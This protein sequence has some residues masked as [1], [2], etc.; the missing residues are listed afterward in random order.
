MSKVI[1]ETIAP[2]YTFEMKTTNSPLV[3]NIS[4]FNHS[5][6][7]NSTTS[8][9]ILSTQIIKYINYILYEFT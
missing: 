5:Y 1:I 8:L 6:K 3:K 4:L 2:Y 9:S 7:Y